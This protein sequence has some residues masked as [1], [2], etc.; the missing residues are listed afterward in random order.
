MKKRIA[1]LV[2]ALA[3]IAHFTLFFANCGISL[4]GGV[5]LAQGV[6]Y[7][8]DRRQSEN[9]FVYTPN[10]YVRPVVAYG[11]KVMNYGKFD[12]M[13]AIL[14]QRGWNVVG[15]MNGGFFIP[16]TFQPMGIVVTEGVLRSSDEGLHAVGFRSDGSAMFGDPKLTMNVTIDG[17]EFPIEYYNKLRE[18]GFTLFSSDFS[19]STRSKAAGRD[20]ILSPAFSGELKLNGTYE[21]AVR[22]IKHNAGAVDIADGE[23]ILSLG[24]VADAP[25]QDAMSRLS[26]GSRITVTFTAD[27]QWDDAEYAVG[28]IMWIVREGAAVPAAIEACPLPTQQVPRTALG[29]RSDGTIVMYTVDGRQSNHSSGMTAQETADRMIELGCREVLMLDG[30]GSTSFH[31][32][33]VGAPQVSQ[34]SSPSDGATADGSGSERAVTN[35]IMLAAVVP[36]SGVAKSIDLWPHN[37]TMYA[38]GENP[39]VLRAADET[40]RPVDITYDFASAGKWIGLEQLESPGTYTIAAEYNGMRAESTVTVLDRLPEIETIEGFELDGF[41]AASANVTLSREVNKDR[42]RFGQSS[43]R[44]DYDSGGGFTAGESV[45]LN[46]TVGAHMSSLSFWVY[47]PPM[48]EGGVAGLAVYFTDG[49]SAVVPLFEDNRGMW[50]QV[51][52]PIPR[53]GVGIVGIG[54]SGGNFSS[55]PSRG[56]VWLDQ[57]TAGTTSGVD[58]VP[59][60]IDTMWTSSEPTEPGDSRT[61]TRFGAEVSD[62]LGSVSIVALTLDGKSFPVPVNFDGTVGELTSEAFAEP[63]DRNIHRIALTLSDGSGNLVRETLTLTPS[64]LNASKF[65]DTANHWAAAYIDY[66]EAQGVVGGTSVFRPDEPATRAEFAVMLYNWTGAVTTEYASLVKDF[67]DS[68][69][70]PASAVNAVGWAFANGYIKGMNSEGEPTLFAPNATLTRAQAMTI[71]GRMQAFGHRRADLTRFKDVDA[72]PAWSHAYLEELVGRGVISGYDDGSLKPNGNLTRAEV[73]KILYALR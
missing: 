73:A 25:L 5:E 46:R 48:T 64:E 11:S 43:A 42:V 1:S 33:Y 20:A 52:V 10:S 27:A 50:Q 56:S 47:A 54:V 53:V 28:S 34:I 72:I 70:I 30:G 31:A 4:G 45:P 17:G 9:Y 69:A 71:I 38:R 21:F 67:A 44:L 41:A 49:T 66:L 26:A 18:G 19:T 24:D 51:T 61:M 37:A 68:S 23:Y 7:I 57:M 12:A 39:L 62:N 55:F 2:L 32:R 13:A 65:S 36:G 29:L 15:G 35:Y 59:P 60:S 6:H 16:Q 3:I 14:E 8:G 58:I 22:E 63:N 40:C